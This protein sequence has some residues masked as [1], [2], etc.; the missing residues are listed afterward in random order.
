[1]QGVKIYGDGSLYGVLWNKFGVPGQHEFMKVQSVNVGAKQI[2]FWNNIQNAYDLLGNVQIVRVPYY[3]SAT[4]TG[5]LFCNPW[6]PGTKSGGV[7][8]MIIGRTIKLQA[9]INVTGEGFSGG[10]SSPGAG[11]CYSSNAIYQN[12]FYDEGDLNSGFKGE[13]AAN[14]VYYSLVDN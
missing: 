10:I 9:D 4:V 11:N 5:T 1:M 7:L 6:N 8:A 3:N 14:Y 12:E 13:G 2:T